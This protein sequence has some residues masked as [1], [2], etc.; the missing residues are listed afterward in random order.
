[1]RFSRLSLERYGRFQDCELA[2][3]PGSPDLHIIYGANEAGK[4]TSL[5]AVSDLLF[6]F[7]TRSPYNFLFDYTLLRVG[8]V[9]EDG[10][11]TLACRRKKGSAGTLLDASD[12]AMAEAPLLAMLKGQTRE[13]FGLSF[14][15]DQAALRQGG[16][17]MVEA[18]N[19]LGRT[20]FAAGSGLT[21][22]A[23]EL[24]A[25]EN[26]AEAIWGP[27]T[28]SSRTFTQALKQ[29]TDA[30]K[31]VRDEALKPKAWSDAKGAS[32]R[33]RAALDAVRDERDA[34]QAEV[35]A[36][37]RVRRLAPLARRREEHL[38]A[39]AGFKGTTDLTRTREDAAEKVIGEAEDAIREK[40]AVEQLLADIAD[41]RSKVGGDA[42]A[43]EHADEIDALVGGAGAEDK[44]ARDLA[45]L[46]SDHASASAL[47]E[48][49]RTEAGTNAGVTLPR[50]TAANLRNLGRANGELSASNRQLVEGRADLD[51]RRR[52]AT[53]RL[54]STSAQTSFDDLIDAVDAARSLGADVDA[55]REAALRKAEGTAAALAAALQRL[56]PWA[57]DVGDLV[58]LP[59]VGA[60][61]IEAAR[62][63]ILELANE[64]KREDEEHR[65]SPSQN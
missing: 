1:V 41:R 3:R 56:R 57:G 17:A 33:T 63:A 19:D 46:S 29:H 4:T 2:F 6:G 53:A 34:I 21:G 50:A 60:A 32:E 24:R 65:R 11:R 54:D 62:L 48:R 30:T 31:S 47:V 59:G 61:E 38:T 23:D 45:Q 18:K 22:I 58:R 49:L 36:A 43:L 52:R 27:T 28:K 26:E 55:R 13:T 8:A 7:P 14:S 37:E 39:L 20:L 40:A 44:A 64:A 51:E 9:L 42:A 35:R 5:S 15:L 16:R 10:G 25:L 12:A